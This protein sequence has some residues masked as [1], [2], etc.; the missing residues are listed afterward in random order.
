M[1]EMMARNYTTLTD[2]TSTFGHRDEGSI[3]AMHATLDA[4]QLK[5]KS[6][7][8]GNLRDRPRFLGS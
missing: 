7:L 4:N 3:G 6:Y 1:P 5:Y 8:W 2:A